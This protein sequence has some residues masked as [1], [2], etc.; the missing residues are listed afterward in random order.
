[1]PPLTHISYAKYSN[2]P[3]FH[4]VCYN[5]NKLD[6]KSNSQ[7]LHKKTSIFLYFNIKLTVQKSFIFSTIH[8]KNKKHNQKLFLFLAVKLP[9]TKI[10]LFCCI[11]IHHAL[12]P[13]RI[14]PPQSAPSLCSLR[15]SRRAVRSR[16]ESKAAAKLFRKF[17][18]DTLCCTGCQRI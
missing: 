12:A 7:Y 13:P 18:T 2:H 14:S 16:R 15:Y 6:I 17:C 8:K 3:S 10:V 9:T 4:Y 11:R 5:Y 1:M